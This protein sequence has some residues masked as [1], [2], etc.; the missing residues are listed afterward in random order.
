MLLEQGRDMSPGCRVDKREVSGQRRLAEVRCKGDMLRGA[1]SYREHLDPPLGDRCCC[2]NPIVDL[3]DNKDVVQVGLQPLQDVRIAEGA[4]GTPT[5]GV[6]LE[7]VLTAKGGG[8]V[9]MEEGLLDLLQE[10]GEAVR[11]EHGGEGIREDVEEA[12]LVSGVLLGSRA[13]RC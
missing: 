9:T 11:G 2:I 4:R 12:L 10:D 7:I 13:W 6:G 1:A 5:R 8:E 3:P